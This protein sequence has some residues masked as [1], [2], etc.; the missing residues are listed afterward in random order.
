MKRL[1]LYCALCVLI[2]LMLPV[3]AFA[4]TSSRHPRHNVRKV[5]AHAVSFEDSLI[6]GLVNAGK[7]WLSGAREDWK[8]HV[9]EYKMNYMRV[10]EKH[11][12]ETSYNVLKTN[13]AVS[14]YVGYY[15]VKSYRRRTAYFVWPSYAEDAEFEKIFYDVETVN[16]AYQHGKWVYVDVE[17]K[18]TE[19]PDQ[20]RFDR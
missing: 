19:K 3:G 12:G 20:G 5:S 14:P 8:E 16:F 1:C 17:S 11:I 4:Q 2:P 18:G 6:A 15:I 7:R 10:G 13:S 9:I